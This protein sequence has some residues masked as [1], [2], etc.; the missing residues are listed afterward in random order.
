MGL[1]PTIH[2]LCDAWIAS[3]QPNERGARG[4]G[5]R[6]HRLHA[7]GIVFHKLTYSELRA[8]CVG[9][10]RVLT[11]G[12]MITVVDRDHLLL[13]T[14]IG[15]LVLY[16]GDPAIPRFFGVEETEIR[17]LFTSALCASFADVAQPAAPTSEEWTRWRQVRQAMVP[18]ALDQFLSRRH[19]ILAYLSFPLLEA[20]LKKAAARYISYAGRVKSEWDAPTISPLGILDS[21]NMR[22]RI[23]KV[24]STCSSLRDLLFLVFE[25]VADA[26]LRQDLDDIRAHLAEFD[27]TS[28]DAFERLYRWRNSSLHGETMPTRD[29]GHRPHNRISHRPVFAAGF[30]SGPSNGNRQRDRLGGIVAFV[31]LLP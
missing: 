20:L 21:S 9:L 17:E 2:Q 13:W 1:E 6:E 15:D 18:P 8:A 22:R 3:V 12:Q 19:L 27:G 31:W 28:I 23:Y 11:F 24:G 29:W 7:N 26:D 30:L 14:W 10:L 5:G 16:S 25:R 4:I